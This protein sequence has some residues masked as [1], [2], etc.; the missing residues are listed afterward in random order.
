MKSSKLLLRLAA[1]TLSLLCAAAALSSCDIF[2]E[3]FLSEYT[4][5]RTS[6]RTEAP[7]P[8]YPEEETPLTPETT[9]EAHD[10][11]IIAPE[12]TALPETTA[13]PEVTEPPV[14]AEFADHV[15]LIAK[16]SGNCDEMVGVVYV[17]VFFVNDT[18]SS[19]DDNTAESL[20]TSFAEQEKMLEADASAYGK[21]IDLI[22]KYTAVNISVE[23]DTSNTDDDWQDAALYALGLGSLS[24][25]Q[26]TLQA[27]NGGDSNPIVFAVNNAGRAYA[28]WTSGSRSERVTLYSSSFDSFRHELCHLYGAR[29]F[30]YPSEAEDLANK[31]IADSLMCRGEKIDALINSFGYSKL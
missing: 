17:N 15:Y 22:F 27:Q 3:T 20:K 19:W 24:K 6:A 7:S 2:V 28:S 16:D 25:A 18:V 9:E 23:V 21:E 12:T 8:T 10:V 4:G 14:P 30:Y 11:I 31:H 13:E 1:L 29:D 5:V 26:T